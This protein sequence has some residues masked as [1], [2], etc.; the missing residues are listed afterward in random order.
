MR[1]HWEAGLSMASASSHT[2]L[3]RIAGNFRLSRLESVFLW[4]FF[5]VCSEHVNCP[6]LLFECTDIRGLSFCFGGS[7]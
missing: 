1:N 3:Y 6:R 5:V 7:P 4:S 2:I